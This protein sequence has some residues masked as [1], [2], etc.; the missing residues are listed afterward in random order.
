MSINWDTKKFSKKDV[1][2]I[3]EVLSIMSDECD[4]R[5]VKFSQFNRDELW[6]FFMAYR[7]YKLSG[8]PPF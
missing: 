4:T 3:I 2:S 1:L 7:A 5:G 6:E 8:I